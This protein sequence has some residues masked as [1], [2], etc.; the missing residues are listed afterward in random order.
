MVSGETAPGCVILPF[1]DAALLAE[2]ASVDAAVDLHA[3]LS[4]DRH[5][6][7]TDIVPAARTVLVR[8]GGVSPA[9]IER[10]ITE[11]AAEPTATVE[12][13]GDEV[14]IPLRYDGADL[15]AVAALLGMSAAALVDRHTTATWRVAFTGFAPGFAYLTSVDWPY[16]VPRL[17]RPRTAV[18]AG[19]VGLAGEFAG[20]YPRAS[21]GGWQLI[22][23]TAAAL[24]DPDRDPAVLLRP[25][26]RVR[27]REIVPSVSGGAAPASRAA[28]PA[29]PDA[30]QGAGSGREDDSPAAV[31]VLSPGMRASIQDAGR[32]GH[33][34]DG[35]AESGAADRGALRRANRLV[36]NRGGAAGVEILLGGFR[37]RSQRALWIAVTGAVGAVRIDGR[38]AATH[39]ATPWPAETELEIDG[40]DTGARIILAVRGGIEAPRIAGSR[41]MDSLAGF[42]ATSLAAGTRLHV[43]TDV[44]AAIP[45]IDQ[46]PGS[47]P[48][49]VVHLDLTPGP[50]ADWLTAESREAL[51]G[52]VWTVSGEADRTGVRLDGPR[53]DRARVE[54]LP[55]EGMLPG[56]I[57]VP[58]D[59][60]PVIL[61]VD[62]PVTGGYPVVAVVTD[63]DRDLLGQLRPGTRIRFHLRA[64]RGGA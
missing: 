1:G 51:T 59:G 37:A 5:P 36:G 53:L 2:V 19:A 32:R 43:A 41:A 9:V 21:P 12:A 45:V 3:R 42:G 4:A 23:T 40:A 8:F 15:P 39:A 30:R 14:E 25:G 26:V 34:A 46:I 58:P 27:F 50:R 10:W 60:R 28:G 35:F 62:G 20:A 17:A 63:A 11:R 24:F 29:E 6:G 44:A 57:Q 64:V 22:G 33:A 47:L 52:A 16:D 54:E 13:A 48:A 31:T 49:E 7:V 18:P 38:P 61:G 55:S 56:A